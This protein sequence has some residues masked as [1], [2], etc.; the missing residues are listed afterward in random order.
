MTCLIQIPQWTKLIPLK[1]SYMNYYRSSILF[2][3]HLTCLSVVS[4][5]IQPPKPVNALNGLI[6]TQYLAQT[7]APT[8]IDPLKLLNPYDSYM[9][10]GYAAARE[11]NYQKAIEEFK[12]ALVEK[13]N[14]VYAEQAI[15]NMENYLLQN[16][17]PTNSRLNLA[18]LRWL[19]PLLAL[20]G[21]GAIAAFW[22]F[23]RG[24]RPSAFAGKP[25]VKNPFIRGDNVNE[26]YET[27]FS[28]EDIEEEGDVW[29]SSLPVQRTT[30]IPNPELVDELL[31]ELQSPEPKRR[32]RA[33]W[34]LAQNADSRAMKPLVELMIDTDSY[35]RNLILEALSQISA[36]TIKP[37]NQALALS[38]QDKNPQVRKNAIRDLT[39][40]YDM[41]SQVSQLLCHAIDDNDEEVQETAKWA[42]NQLNLQM[43]PRLDLLLNKNN[44]GMNSEVME[45]DFYGKASEVEY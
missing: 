40:L 13:P 39:R 7:P 6:I 22:L 28:P 12:K 33:I 30:R 15:Q 44:N 17:Q 18:F 29:D 2:A 9:Q 27:R 38:L 42:L 19:I 10:E 25:R 34:K 23:N 11:K 43:P 3:L 26:S 35:E 41:M 21:V 37:M 24:Q 5:G 16:P 14:D 32:R 31:R 45:E 4:L 36:R 1:L 20:G 8:P